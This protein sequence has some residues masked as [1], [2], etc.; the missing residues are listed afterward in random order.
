ME[1]P[2]VLLGPPCTLAA[3]LGERGEVAGGE[4]LWVEP[5][6]SRF[7]PD[8]VEEVEVER[9]TLPANMECNA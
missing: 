6:V 5:V 1:L 9:G 4:V 2:A 8:P 7:S 3:G